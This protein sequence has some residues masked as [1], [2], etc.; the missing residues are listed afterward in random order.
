MK[1]RFLPREL[2]Y[3]LST[4]TPRAETAPWS[5]WREWSERER[6]LNRKS[7]GL[8]WSACLLCPEKLC[9]NHR[10]RGW[11]AGTHCLPIHGAIGIKKK[12]KKDCEKHKQNN[13]PVSSTLAT[14]KALTKFRT[15]VL[16]LGPRQRDHCPWW[17]DPGDF[18]MPLPAL[19]SLT[20]PPG[21][22]VTLS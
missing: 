8:G 17:P 2:I 10:E 14:A 4:Y 20:P 13:K 22:F 6:R 16:P 15:S 12:K 11:A 5:V 7:S 18:L 3:E 1:P 21:L 9:E 19:S